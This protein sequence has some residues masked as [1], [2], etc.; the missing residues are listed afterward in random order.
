MRGS[1]PRLVTG[2]VGLTLLGLGTPA[3][4]AQPQPSPANLL[5]AG[6]SLFVG[7]MLVSPNGT[8]QLVLQSDGNLVLSQVSPNL[9]LWSSQT[10]GQPSYVLT[11]QTDGNL[12]LYDQA[13]PPNALWNSQ[14][15]SQGATPPFGAYLLLQDD[16]NLVV[17]TALP[18]WSAG[19]GPLCP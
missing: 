7:Q 10:A 17:Y 13:T 5:L 15:S 14:T 6:Q 19:T 4:W 3:A 18:C 8:F 16:G 9:A 2:I 12:V 11:M 1:A